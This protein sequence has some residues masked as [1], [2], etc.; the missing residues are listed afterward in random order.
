ML[1]VRTEA[2]L[3]TRMTLQ[4]ASRSLSLKTTKLGSGSSISLSIDSNGF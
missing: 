4:A 3:Q 1:G 2:C